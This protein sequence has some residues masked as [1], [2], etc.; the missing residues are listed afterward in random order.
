[1]KSLTERYIWRVYYGVFL[2]SVMLPY[3]YNCVAKGEMLELPWSVTLLVL[4]L[5]GAQAVSDAL[6]VLRLKDQPL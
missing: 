3:G 2:G 1:L 5:T 6:A 4:G